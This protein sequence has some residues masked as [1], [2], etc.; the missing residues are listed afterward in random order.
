MEGQSPERTGNT[1]SIIADG[2]VW[3]PDISNSERGRA[4][5][6]GVHTEPS[7]TRG[8]DHAGEGFGAGAVTTIAEAGFAVPPASLSPMFAITDACAGSLA[9]VGKRPAPA[10]F[11]PIGIAQ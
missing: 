5:Q 1:K 2:R 8:T 6:G 10:A 11:M 7:A 3:V 4:E 9:M